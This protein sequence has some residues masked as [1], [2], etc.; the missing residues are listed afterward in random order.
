MADYERQR[1]ALASL[2]FCNASKLPT[3]TLP[4]TYRKPMHHARAKGNSRRVP[5]SLYRFELEFQ[6]DESS[7]DEDSVP[8][9]PAIGTLQ[10]R[11]AG[12]LSCPF[13]VAF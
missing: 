11:R 5:G 1:L 3:M 13:I 8:G 6:N 10:T 4:D 12:E 9:A 7:S 2:G